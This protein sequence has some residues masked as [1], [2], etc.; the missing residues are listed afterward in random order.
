MNFGV[1]MWPLRILFQFGIARAKDAPV[2][3]HMDFY[4]SVI[5]WNVSFARA[6]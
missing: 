4:G 2:E 6:A 1:G 3:A 5:Q